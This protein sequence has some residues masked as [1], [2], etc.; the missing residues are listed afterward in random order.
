MVG[1]KS[2]FRV[3]LS[4]FFFCLS[5]V[6]DSN[7]LRTHPGVSELV[8]ADLSDSELSFSVPFINHFV[9]KQ[10]VVWKLP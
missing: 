4:F 1:Q 10:N 2:E 9:F 3:L 6:V 5:L 8:N 7:H